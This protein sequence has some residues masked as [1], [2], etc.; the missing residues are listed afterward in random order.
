MPSSSPS[1]RRLA[2]TPADAHRHAQAAAL[3]RD[4]ECRTG[5]APPG[6]C[7]SA[8][9]P[10]AYYPG[11]R[12]TRIGMCSFPPAFGE[13][14]PSMWNA[15]AGRAATY[16]F[17]SNRLSAVLHPAPPADRQTVCHGGRHREARLSASVSP[18]THH[19]SHQARLISPKLQLLSGHTSEQSLAV[20]RELALSR[21]IVYH[22]PKTTQRGREVPMP[23]Y[24]E[25]TQR[26]GSLRALT[27]LTEAEFHSLAAPF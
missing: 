19:V 22:L 15:S 5:P 18:P 2:R 6:R 11:Q 21:F 24:E 8:Y 23:S 10:A 13:S 26:A 17:E 20:Y 3:Y 1:M 7:R 14:S 12:A 4:P 27:G 25:V 9:L 16:L